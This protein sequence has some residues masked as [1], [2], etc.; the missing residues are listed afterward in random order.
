MKKIIVVIVLLLLANVLSAQGQGPFCGGVGT[1]GCD[2]IKADSSAILAWAT[3][4]TIVRGPQNISMPDS[5]LVTFGEDE[6][7]VLGPASSYT[8]DAVSLGD[9]GTATLTFDRPIRNGNGPDFAVFE[10][11][12]KNNQTG[13]YFLELAFVE[14][15]SD[16]EHFVR[17]PATS[18]VQDSVQAGPF[19]DTDPT[20]INNLA[21][22]YQVGY[23]TPFDLEE[24][25]DSS[26]LDI[27]A[28]THVRIVDVVGAIDSAYASYDA[29]GHIVNDPW[30][31]NFNS[32]G[33]DLTGVA[34]MH[35]VGEDVV[36]H[37][38]L[39]VVAYPNPVCE[40]LTVSGLLRGSRVR[41]IDTMGRTLS[42][43][44]AEGDTMAI[45]MDDLPK[46]VY[47]LSVDQSVLRLV[48]Y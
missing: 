2:A 24:L 45:A 30:P 34:V 13:G 39:S 33:F 16:G 31:T 11:A 8:T 40:M 28:V 38:A 1:A 18:L 44:V 41:L 27:D 47:L 42:D 43:V 26:G 32:G 4:V 36:G 37:E 46:G 10:N 5:P 23:G 6:S 48:K 25:K 12:M 35:Q 22:K 9:G 29:F 14:V 7:V 15:S 17:F 20:L 21:G 3:G 19:A